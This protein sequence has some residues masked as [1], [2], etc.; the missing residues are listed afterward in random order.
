ML[1]IHPDLHGEA[2]PQRL[3]DRRAQV[4]KNTGGGPAHGLIV[5]TDDPELRRAFAL[6]SIRFR[7]S[8]IVRVTDVSHQEDQRLFFIRAARGLCGELGPSRVHRF[9]PR[10]DHRDTPACGRLDERVDRFCAQ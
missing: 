5:M 6:P 3:R 8:D 4:R 2:A 1:G 7:E 10:S 9:Q